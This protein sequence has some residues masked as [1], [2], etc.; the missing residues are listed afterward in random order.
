MKQEYTHITV[1]LDRSGSMES[2]RNDVVGGFN[3]FLAEQQTASGTATMTLVQFDTQNPYEVLANFQ[4]IGTVAPLTRDLY[5]PRASTPLLDAIGRGIND[6]EATLHRMKEEERPAKVIFLIVTD[7]QENS[8]REFNRTQ[9]TQMISAHEEKEKWQFVYISADL[10][11]IEDARQYGVR[12]SHV[13][14]YDKTAVGAQ[15]AFRSVS[16]NTRDW[17]SG[18]APAPAFTEEDRALHEAE[19]QRKK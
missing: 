8:S 10:A 5:V 15:S 3:A 4:L 16:K 11:A 14:A 6:L 19:Q 17:R 2:I 13:M 7:G 9:I 12:P 18:A 1:I